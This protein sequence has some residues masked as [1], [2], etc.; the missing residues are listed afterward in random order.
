MEKEIK[1]NFAMEKPGK[2]HFREVNQVNVNS[3]KSC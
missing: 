2:Q 1:N 3:D